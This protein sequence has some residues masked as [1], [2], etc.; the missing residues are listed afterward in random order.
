MIKVFKPSQLPKTGKL[1]LLYGDTG[2]GKTVTSLKTLPKP[3]LWITTEPRDL[4]GPMLAAGIGEKDGIK[5]E[6]VFIVPYTDFMEVLE[7]LADNEYY[8]K[9]KSI[10]FDSL[11]YFQGIQL[12]QEVID[13]NFDNKTDKGTKIITAKAKNT[14]EGFGVVN[15]SVFRVLRLLGLQ[16]SAGKAVV[17]TCLVTE[18][19]KYDRSMEAGP[20][21]VGKQVPDQLPGF[22]DLIGYL[23]PRQDAEGHRVYPPH[24]SFK[25]GEGYLAKY[26]GKD[27]KKEGPL[28]FG[29]ILGS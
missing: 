11:S 2:L 6:D 20:M 15:N 27:G 26:T 8:P 1:I 24:V 23:R 10:L 3:I 25:E 12:T 21:L 4:N 16:S 7:F 18:R 13:E 17:V 22:C 9:V 28:D 29:K 19:P 14:Q 5:E